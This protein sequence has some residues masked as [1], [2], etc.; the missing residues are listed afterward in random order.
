MSSSGRDCNPTTLRIR[1]SDAPDCGFFRRQFLQTIKHA[2]QIL[3][4][5][6]ENLVETSDLVHLASQGLVAEAIVEASRYFLGGDDARLNNA[7]EMLGVASTGFASIGAITHHGL[8]RLLTQTLPRMRSRST[9]RLLR[10]IHPDNQIWSR[11]LLLLARGLGPRIEENSG[12]VELW[13]SQVSALDRGL[14]DQ[15]TST[16]VRMPTSAGKTRIAEMAMVN[17]L[18][19]SPGDCCLY[20]APFK[21][22]AGEIEASLS[23]LFSDLGFRLSATLG[24][25]E[26]DEAEQEL[27]AAADV[28]IST[29]E[30]LDLLLRV[31]RSFFDRVGL[32]VIDEGQLV[33]DDARGAHFEF[34]L[35]RIRT[36]W[37]QVKFISLSA[38]IPQSTLEDFATWLGSDRATISRSEWR[39]AV[40]RLSQFDW[41]GRRGFLRFLPDNDVPGIE[42]FLPS[43]MEVQTYPFINP[44]TG[45]QNNPRFPDVLIK[46]QTAA[47]LAYTLAPTG[48]VLV[49]CPT[50][51]IAESVSNAIMKRLQLTKQSGAPVFHEFSE[52][53]TRS[54]TI[55]AD[56]L[57]ADHPLT[58]RLRNG[59]A[60][61][62]GGVPDAVKK[63]IERDFRERNFQVIVATSTLAQGVNLPIK[64]V[65]IHSSS[66]HD[67]DTNIRLMA[68]EYWNI[69][70]RA[71]RAGEETEG[72]IVH[73]C[74]TPNDLRALRWYAAKK[75]DLEPLESALLKELIRLVSERITDPKS[76]QYL[77]SDLLAL[78]V[79]EDINEVTDVWVNQVFGST[80]AAMEARRTSGNIVSITQSLRELLKSV[81]ER[82]PDKQR[83]INFSTTGLCV[84]SCQSMLNH[85]NEHADELRLL[86]TSATLSDRRKLIGIFLE[87]C[88]S[89]E[90]IQPKTDPSF[91]V[92]ELA[93]MWISGEG[94]SAIRTSFSDSNTNP[95]SISSFI[96][97]TFG[98]RL[99]WGIS[100]YIR[101]AV[102]ELDLDEAAI[103]SVV[104]FFPSMIKYGVPTPFAVW[105]IT[106]GI[107]F[108]T[109]PS[110]SAKLMLRMIPFLASRR[111]STGLRNGPSTA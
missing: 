104:R 45:R 81:L 5:P 106:A 39:P 16:M 108:R 38:V 11:Y 48:A 70:G 85:I 107:N 14:F 75:N 102:K 15:G 109:W 72:V 86:L 73:I 44:E 46:A 55:C 18:I 110:S 69:A 17:H 63:A 92:A 60:V 93:E 19:S 32:I 76:I 105:G 57:G 43:I 61:H 82:V 90:E 37:P 23:G 84:E 41:Q 89:A 3:Q 31:N 53:S 78:L 22:L 64:T 21:A 59:V 56:W 96:E 28:I 33:E 71:G 79:E 8:V 49:F 34:L 26:T 47:E 67:G 52:R 97:D 94:Y 10:P 29:P 98:Y 65:I 101:L 111:S 9:W 30:K 99:P 13:P 24:S 35:T 74:Q 2:S 42:G 12:I 66:R 1:R 50:R 20:I 68:R 77:D 87:G 83:R 58:T 27:L 6:P 51:P 91:E 80:L 100:A 4:S 62:H 7:L 36:G 40:Q 54:S 95:E 103:S 88:F 25:F